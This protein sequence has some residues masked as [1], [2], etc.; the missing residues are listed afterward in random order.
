MR[1]TKP[2]THTQA[3]EFYMEVWYVKTQAPMAGPS[4]YILLEIY[5]YMGGC[6]N[7][8]PFWGTLN[9]RCRII[10]GIHKGTIILTTI[11]MKLYRK[12]ER[13][14]RPSCE[15]DVDSVGSAAGTWQG[16]IECCAP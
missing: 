13:I 14:L 6:Q 8:D 3:K 10:V 15:S 4:V 1:T 11:H 12:Y 5:T 7:Y 2:A 9:S 16:S